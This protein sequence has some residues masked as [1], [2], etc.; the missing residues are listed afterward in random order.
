MQMEATGQQVQP[1][2]QTPARSRSRTGQQ[3]L[4]VPAHG[5]AAAQALAVGAPVAPGFANFYA[6]VSRPDAA[7]V[8]RI[9]TIKGRPA[10]HVGS[11]TTT[12]L[13]VPML[14]DWSRLPAGVKV[15]QVMGLI[16]ALFELGPFGFRGPAASHL[17]SHL[18]SVD[19][20]VRTTQI[21]APGLDCP[22]NA[23]FAR[24]MDLLDEDL[25]FITSANRS[26]RATGAA[27]EPAHYLSDKLVDD[28]GPVADDLVVLRHQDEAAARR[29]Y[30]RHVPTSTSILSF[31]R[32]APG[33]GIGCRP[34]LVLERH[35]SLPIGDVR[36]IA[37]RF[38]FDVALGA[39]A[40]LRLQQRQYTA[41]WSGRP[42]PPREDADAPTGASVIRIKSLLVG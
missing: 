8:R 30:P 29:R 31:H 5:E 12:P 19:E 16:E 34:C 20:G 35:G 27:E 26:R 32:L 10:D 2:T 36:A 14:F 11:V 23:F 42:L 40:A 39:R 28:L 22:S 3:F 41:P 13:R 18:T 1:S 38:G 25:L 4:G 15:H 17:P 24:A 33:G 21:I 7:T 37:D 6:L 9:N